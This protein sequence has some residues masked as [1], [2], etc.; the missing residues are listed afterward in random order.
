MIFASFIVGLY[1]YNLIK[2]T[3]E[4]TDRCSQAI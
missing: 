1:R 2:D 4:D 3:T